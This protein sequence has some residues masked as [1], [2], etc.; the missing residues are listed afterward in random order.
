MESVIYKIR[1]LVNENF[2]VGST[3]NKKERWRTHRNKLRGNRHHCRHLQ[4]AWNLYGEEKFLFEVVEHVALETELQAAE[5]VWL[6]AHVGKTHC[7]NHGTRSGAPMRGRLG[8]LH[9]SYGSTLSEDRKDH[10]RNAAK[11]QW[12]TT[13]PR[14]GRKHTEEAVAK[15]KVK[16]QQSI[17]EGRGGCFIPSEETRQKMSA[18]LMGKYKGVPKP[19]RTDEHRRRLSEATKGNTNFKGKRHREETKDLMRRPIV[20]RLPDNSTKTFAGLSVLRDELGVSLMTIVRACGRGLPIKTGVCAGWVLSYKDG[21]QNQG[22]PVPE[23]Y[24]ELPRTRQE[25][26][27][28]GAKEYFT[29]IPCERGHVAPRKT[30][31]TCTE[32]MKE[33]WSKENARRAAQPK[34]A[35]SKE[36]GRRYYERNKGLVKEKAKRQ[37]KPIDTVTQQ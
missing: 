29:G 16:V 15:I 11:Q 9:P 33:D 28:T 36:A 7:Y 12:K 13:D 23:Q 4:A 26:K 34:S 17:A 30:K 25:A 3:N 14:T 24:I 20:A 5:D 6:I 2:Y 37:A 27:T 19:L 18:A 22:P 8:E 35:A 10:L 1:N 32:C 21:E 31:G